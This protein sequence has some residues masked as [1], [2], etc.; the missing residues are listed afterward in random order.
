MSKLLVLHYSTYGHTAHLAAAVAEG[1]RS[2]SDTEVVVK[3]VPELMPA[4]MAEKAEA[5]VDPAIDI[6]S[7]AEL[8]DYDAIIFGPPGS[9]I[10][11]RRC[12]IFSTR[13]AASG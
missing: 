3:R 5:V 12:A 11:R 7:P 6:A 9:A 4:E 1:A 8:T 10:W 2:V 13:P